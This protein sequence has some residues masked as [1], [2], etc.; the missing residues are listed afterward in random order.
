MA[1]PLVSVI[2]PTYNSAAFLERS[3]R[4]IRAQDYEPLEIVVADN[5]STDDTVAI[6]HRLADVVIQAGPERCAQCNA[7]VRA[8]HGE[9]VYRVDSDFVLEPGVV[10]AAVELC[11]RGA[12]AVLVN[13][14]SE[15]SV[16][17][18]ARVRY[19]ERCMYK[20]SALHVGARFFRR[21]AFEAVGGFD[22]SLLA[23]ED[24]DIHNR[25]LKAGYRIAGPVA[26]VERHLGEPT[27]LTEIA[28]K[29]FF[30]GRSMGAFLQRNGSRGVAQMSPLRAA[31]VRH[32]RDFVREPRIGAAFVLMQA[33]KYACGA[34]G[35]AYEALRRPRS[36]SR[37]S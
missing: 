4:S 29:S 19:F 9:L 1:R 2:V 10:A 17:F 26:P 6:A 21:S 8:A 22:E 36:A 7:A 13:N 20:D 27:A 32:W 34:A 37:A 24:Y 31:Y 16:S 30:Y 33:V 18:W 28:R 12:D 11:E 35:L 25:L 15:P 14:E 5:A 23:G 3:L